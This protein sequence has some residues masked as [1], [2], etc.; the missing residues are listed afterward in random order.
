L[1]DPAGKSD[2]YPRDFVLSLPRSIDYQGPEALFGR[3]PLDGE[4]PS[5]APGGLDMIR[6][7]PD[8]EV[9]LMK[10]AS[11]GDIATFE[12]ALTPSLRSAVLW[13]W[14][15]TA[16][17]RVRSGRVDHSSMLMHAHSDT[18]VHDS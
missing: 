9:G 6:E 17:R 4:D 3:S 12:P 14:L 13:F 15:A 11:R 16:V 10:P 2:F 18:K 8:D 5:E 7:I 1:A